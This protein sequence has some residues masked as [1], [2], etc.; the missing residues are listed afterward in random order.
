[1]SALLCLLILA[2]LAYHVLQSALAWGGA[3]TLPWYAAVAFPWFWLLMATSAIA[4]RHGRPGYC[5][6]LGVP[7]FF[8]AAELNSTWVTM[9]K[10]YSQKSLSIAAL[11]RLASIHP[12]YLGTA[13]LLGAT[14]AALICL[15]AAAFLC[16]RALSGA[17]ANET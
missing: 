10:A 14:G 15:A 17:D 9:V 4:W 2:G 5:I 6:A 13:T 8:V 3:S 16:I 1:M 12:H 7:I 11:R